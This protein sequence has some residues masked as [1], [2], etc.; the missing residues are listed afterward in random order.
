RDASVALS[1]TSIARRSF[2]MRRSAWR[3]GTMRLR[4]H[5]GERAYR[6][7]AAAAVE[8]AH[9]TPKKSVSRAAPGEIVDRAGAE[10]TVVR[11][12]PSDERRDLLRRADSPHRDL[13]HE[14]I[15]GALLHLLQELGADDG[16]RHRVDEDA[17]RRDFL[18]ERFREADHAGLRGGIRHERRVAF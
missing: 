14:Q 11:G 7:R 8:Q 10:R 18:G 13:R 12:E 9:S 2:S 1:E 15:D 5:T 4:Y 16:G 17:A 3:S 6:R